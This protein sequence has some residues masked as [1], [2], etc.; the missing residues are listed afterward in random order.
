[1]DITVNVEFLAN[2]L[3]TKP[4]DL[5]QALKDGENL[6]SSTEIEKVLKSKWTDR[7]KSIKSDA[8]TEG[9]GRG[10]RESLTDVE[11]KLKDKYSV[12]GENLEEVVSNIVESKTKDIKGE[13]LGKDEIVK[14]EVFL[15]MKTRFTDQLAQKDEQI[16]QMKLEA[17]DKSLSSGLKKFAVGFLKNPDNKFVLPEDENI[18]NNWVDVFVS[19]I[20]DGNSFKVA[21]DGI[22]LVDEKGE[23]LRDDLHNVV[24]LES[25]G[26]NAAKGLFTQAAGQQRSTP[27]VQGKPP[28][29]GTP[30]YSFPETI[31]TM[32]DA[33]KHL[34]TLSDPK[35]IDAFETEL[36]LRVAKGLVTEN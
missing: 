12:K 22:S 33:L 14:S 24:T 30:D 26:M 13:K 2:V 8:H 36:N 23:P 4:G 15:N 9:H 35:K 17:R 6:K 16:N 3:G 19:K 34:H 18:F 11:K 27:P 7:I 29:G 20:K 31:K 10:K 5:T 25:I 32:P 28:A 1:M 21:D